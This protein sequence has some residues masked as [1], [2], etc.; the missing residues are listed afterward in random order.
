M[1]E[2]TR[3]DGKRVLKWTAVPTIFSFTKQEKK[4]KAPALKSDLPPKIKKPNL[5]EGTSKFK[6]SFKLSI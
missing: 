1:W 5:K 6:T 2:N 3:A 4:R